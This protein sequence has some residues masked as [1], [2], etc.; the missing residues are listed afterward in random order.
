MS[1][2]SPGYIPETQLS[3][4][5]FYR[6]DP[7]LVLVRDRL[8]I[9]AGWGVAG[10]ALLSGAVLLVAPALVGVPFEQQ[11]T[12]ISLIQSLLIHPT[13]VAIYVSLPDGLAGLFNSMKQNGIIGEARQPQPESYLAFEGKLMAWADSGWWTALAVVG[14]ILYWL[15]RLLADIPG[16]I[17]KLAPQE[18]RLW[19]RLAM[20]LVYSPLIYAALLSLARFLVGLVFTRRLFRAFKIRINPLHPDGSAGLGAIGR[21]LAL[22]VL[23]ATAIG[24]A[25]TLMAMADRS[26]GRNPFVRAETWVAGMIYLV[27]LP[28]LF[29]DW[30]WGPHRAMLAMRDESLKPWADEFQRSIPEAV[31]SAQDDA[32]KIKATTDRLAEIKRQYELLKESYPVW[33]IQTP[34]LNRLVATSLLPLITSLLS[35]FVPNIRDAVVALFGGGRP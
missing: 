3:P 20:L 10:I 23:V 35:S 17:T 2:E 11:N 9:G 32:G 18:A 33:P 26:A 5:Q 12:L 34:A 29:L 14:V 25:A 19:L 24:A 27:A 30:L 22:S 15:Y 28:L 13:A 8:H 21:M 7:L 31:P 4:E 16:D 6:H 1:D